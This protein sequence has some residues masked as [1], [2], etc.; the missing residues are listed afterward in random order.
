[1]IKNID[2]TYNWGMFDN[3]RDPSN[4]VSNF[5]AADLTT[6]YSAQTVMDFLSNGFKIRIG[7]ASWANNSTNTHIYMAFA[8][9][10]FVGD[11]T[12]PVT[13]R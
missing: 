3:A 10:P 9:H 4:P 11:G 8:E 1:M 7:N 5:L 2:T 12:S 6:V 13:A